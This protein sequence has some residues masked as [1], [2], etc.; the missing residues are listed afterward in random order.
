MVDQE[1]YIKDGLK[2]VEKLIDQDDLPTALGTCHELLKIDPYHRNT[3]SYLEKIE[4]LILKNNIKKVDKDIESTMHLW[5]ENR[6]SDLFDIYSR[7]YQYAP[8]Y[9]RLLGLIEKLKEKFS[10]EQKNARQKAISASIEKIEASIKAEA[11][12]D[13]IQQSNELLQSD[14]F[15]EDA[16]K[17]LK[18]AKGKQIDKMIAANELVIEGADAVRAVEFLESLLGIDP[19]NQHAND[20]L[21]RAREH[22]SEQ[23]K[24]AE[25]IHLNEALTRIGELFSASEYEKVLQACEEVERIDPGNLTA[26]IF[27]AKS[28][29]TM[30]DESDA[31]MMKKMA[32]ESTLIVQ[33]YAKNPGGYVRV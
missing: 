10:D 8:N 2:I 25:Q 28:L 4:K 20:L 15:N 11:F 18:K 17:M 19:E 33:E 5:K 7:L 23:T 9:G 29:K 22:L 6:L 24:L 31:S 14:P 26:K 16:K 13:A 27:R 1:T 12:A 21:A 3:K 30:D 32:D